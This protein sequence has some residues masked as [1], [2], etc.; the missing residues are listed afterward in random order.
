MANYKSGLLNRE[1]T[2]AVC[3]DLFFQKGYRETAFGEIC[4]RTGLHPGSISYHFKGK[5]HIAQFIYA[6]MMEDYQQQL[7]QLFPEEDDLTQLILGICVHVKLM[8]TNP[9]YRRFSCQFTTDCASEILEDQ[10]KSFSPMVYNF[11]QNNVEPEKHEFFLTA[12]VGFDTSINIYISRHTE[13]EYFISNVKYACELYLYILEKE[14]LSRE[15]DRALR[16][17]EKLDIGCDNFKIQLAL[18]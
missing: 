4:K 16:L 2:I 5:A 8:H 6:E 9:S 14:M 3:K 11:L 13:N 10:Y 17:M 18:T 1:K 15:L 12:S 7:K